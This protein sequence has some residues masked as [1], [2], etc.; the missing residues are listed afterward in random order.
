MVVEGVGGE[1]R[2]GVAGGEEGGEEVV[3]E[4]AGGFF[5]GLGISSGAGF[6]DAL[7]DAGLVEMERDVVGDAEVFNEMLVG[8]RFFS[9]Q[10]VV[11]VDCG[12]ADAERVA[13]GGIG[14]VEVQEESDG[15][16]SARDGYAETIAGLDLCAVE[17]EGGLG[18]HAT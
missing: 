8:V 12:E 1:D 2:V 17:G 7:R 9:A 15:V 10:A 13:C 6:G 18:R 11:D 4:V 16:C 14:G 5:D 3:A